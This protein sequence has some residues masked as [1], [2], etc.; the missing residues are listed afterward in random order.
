M[1]Q[2]NI[3]IWMFRN[4][5]RLSVAAGAASTTPTGW[6][7]S[8]KWKKKCFDKTVDSSTKKRKAYRERRFTRHANKTSHK[9]I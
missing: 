5:R 1:P 2:Q 9:R 3:Y 4:L 7:R 6:R 8:P